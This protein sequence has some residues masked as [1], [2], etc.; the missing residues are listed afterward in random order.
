[1]K[2]KSYIYFFIIV[3]LS[4]VFIYFIYELLAVVTPGADLNL[5]ARKIETPTKLF[6]NGYLGVFFAFNY[7][8]NMNWLLIPML[9]L[10][11]ILAKPKLKRSHY[12]FFIIVLF[13]VALIGFKGFFNPR[14]A[15]TLLPLFVF[16]VFELTWKTSKYFNNDKLRFASL[17]F[18][19]CLAGWNFY[20]EALSIRFSEKLSQ[21]I[22]VQSE[23]EIN[24]NEGVEVEDV[25]VF[26]NELETTDNYLIDNAPEFYYHTKKRGHYY[27]N[28]D[29]LLYLKDGRT[30]LLEGKSFDEVSMKLQ[31]EMKC[32]YIFS[33]STYRGYNPRFDKFLDERC[34]LIASDADYRQLYEIIY[35]N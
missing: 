23:K 21:V 24:Q 6:L 35:E 32:K 5:Q 18:L 4:V 26:I 27:W 33:Y 31:K 20:Q 28:G 29:D 15:F 22:E 11:Y 16:L 13:A 10:Y 2:A 25:M 3:L 1:M 9:P 17:A 19:V 30:K 8:G 34:K 14:Y 12:V 7:L